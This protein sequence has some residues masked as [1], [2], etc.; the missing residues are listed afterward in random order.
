MVDIPSGSEPLL[1]PFPL[2]R[3]SRAAQIF[4][5]EFSK[6]G[7]ADVGDEFTD[8]GVAA[9]PVIPQGGVCLSCCQV[10]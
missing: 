6:D 3:D 2:I 9:Q 1:Y 10:S 7:L 4:I 5:L 8:G